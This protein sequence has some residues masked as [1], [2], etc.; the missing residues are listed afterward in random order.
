MGNILNAFVTI[1]TGASAWFLI[2]EVLLLIG[3]SRLFRKS[4]L[5]P[6]LAFVPFYNTLLISRCAKREKDGKVLMATEVINAVSCVLIIL[7]RRGV[8]TLTLPAPII[9]FAIAI[10]LVIYSIRVYT[11]FISLYGASQWW[12]VL[13]IAFNGFIPALI[14]GFNSRYK[15]NPDAAVP[16]T[17]T[18]TKPG[19]A[20]E[21][22]SSLGSNLH[23]FFYDYDWV[24]LPMAV[25]ITALVASIARRDFFTT[26]EGTVKGFL[27]LTCVAI[28]IGCFNSIHAI[29][30]DRESIASM[31]HLSSF[32]LSQLIYQA[33]LCLV[34][35]AIIIQ[36]CTLIGIHFPEQGLVTSWMVLD[37]MVTV[38]LI[39]LASDMLCLLISAVVKSR[40]IALMVLPF[41]LIFQIVFSGSVI[42]VEVWNRTVSK[43]TISNYGAKCIATQANYNARP[44]VIVWDVLSRSRDTVVGADVDVG[45][46][47]DAL[48]DESRPAIRDFREKTIGRVFTVGEIRDFIFN[49]DAM[50]GL[51]EMEVDPEISLVTVLS[52]IKDDE[53]LPLVR[54]LRERV[55]DNELSFGELKEILDATDL[56]KG[57][58]DKKI[59]GFLEI[60]LVVDAVLEIF[61]EK[62]IPTLIKVSEIL[63][64]GKDGLTVDD[65]LEFAKVKDLLEHYKDYEIDARFK[66]GD[67]IDRILAMDSVKQLHGKVIPLKVTLGQIIDAFGEQKARS[68]ILDKTTEVM[69]VDEYEYS[70]DNVLGYWGMLALIMALNAVL[71]IIVVET[72]FRWKRVVSKSKA[73]DRNE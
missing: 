44:L 3:L 36:S 30:R 64:S 25:V 59:F 28:W 29:C 54:E 69:K 56:L 41:V 14:W 27:A 61:S 16:E 37:L 62:T 10:V 50:K 26:M 55:T 22:K 57:I 73:M 65:I 38:F 40:V 21:L 46:L 67:I 24:Y 70:R 11:G 8:L 7:E 20:G 6:W 49:L 39:S 53:G 66:V 33:C 52:L 23:H 47:L 12:I 43:L 60:G 9:F 45:E 58:R 63:E 17:R 35:A 32:L 51:L 1:V 42:D 34:E 2:P 71:C 15:P 5:S 31:R 18:S 68:I 19:W 13:W 4:N 72:A 48:Q